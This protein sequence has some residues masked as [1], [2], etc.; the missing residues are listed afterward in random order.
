MTPARCVLP[1]AT[2]LV[3]RRCLEGRFLL[4]PR[5]VA[6]RVMGYCL[7][8]MSVRYGVLVHGVS[9][10]SNH[11]HAVVTDP[12]G[13]VS[14]FA[15]DFHAL[16]A[17]VLNAYY[18]RRDSFWSGEP[19]S[20]VRLVTAEDVL[21]KL[22][23]TLANPVS[24]RLV[25]THRDWPGLHSVPESCTHAPRRFSRPDKL[26]RRKG[27]LPAEAELAITVPPQF[28]DMTPHDF[29]QLLRARV[30]AREEEVQAE[31]KA[32]GARFLGPQRVVA[33][34]RDTRGPRKDNA[35]RLDPH[36]ACR[37]PERRV[38]ALQHLARFR[39]DYREARLAWRAGNRDVIFPAGTV[40]LRKVHGVPCHPPPAWAM[41]A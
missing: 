14:D 41:A 21:D 23:Y 38:A 19:A 28:A 24:A 26:L 16:V 39:A 5:E 29:A 40:Q 12:R 33:Q 4:V 11:W 13:E 6:V 25:R 20:L 37:D 27:P 32:E 35:G 22:V 3:T 10:M 31:V 2:W 7:A 9:A 1:G 8:V 30:Q 18:G 36:I 17:R 34:R 15:R